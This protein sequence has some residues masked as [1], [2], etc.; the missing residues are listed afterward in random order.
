M[1][2]IR[3]VL[4]RYQRPVTGAPASDDEWI[5]FGPWRL[6]LGNRT[7]LRDGE[8]VEISTGEFSK[9]AVLVSHPKQPLTRDKLMTLSR[10]REHGAFDRS[11]DVQISRLRRLIEENPSQPR[12][13]QTVWGTGYVFVPQPDSPAE[14]TTQ[15]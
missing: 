9:L 2:R 14:S 12:Y 8:P 7:L 6:G 3:A 10:G 1:A 5:Q 15:A 4:R 11:I 13:I